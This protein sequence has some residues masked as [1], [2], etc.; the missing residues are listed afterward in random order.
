CSCQEAALSFFELRPSA[1]EETNM[2][3]DYEHWSRMAAEW[4]AWA[5]GPNHDAFWAYRTSLCA[6]IG[7]GQ[8]EALD[9]GCG[10]G[11]VSGALKD[12]GYCVPATDP[13]EAI[14]S[15]AEQAGSAHDYKVAAAANLP[16]ADNTFDLAIA[17]NVLMDI[18]DVSA[19][20][21]EIG[22]VLRPAGT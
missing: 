15:A 21:R 17:Y 14:V 18:E 10:A 22:R 2:N 4:I 20:V 13:V 9:V 19:A 1:W 11:R 6:F 5:R 12:C 16:F 8:G 7:G 3:F